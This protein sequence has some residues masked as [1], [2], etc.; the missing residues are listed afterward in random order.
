MLWVAGQPGIDHLRYF[1]MLVEERRD[2][3]GIAAVALHA[4]R[5][6]LDAAQGE[7]RVE[8]A[9]NRADGVLQETELLL[10]RLVPEDGRAANDIRMP[11]EVFR[12]RV[13]HDVEAVLQRLL[14]PRRGEGVVADGN[15]AALA[16]DGGDGLQVDQLEQRIGRGLD[17]DHFRIRLDGLLKR[18]HLGKVRE[19]RADIG[20]ALAHL[21]ED[22]IAAAVEVVHGDDVRARVEEL[23]H[24]A[25]RRH[26]GGEG[27]A[28]FA[29]F[30]LRD[31][32]LE[33]IARGIA[34]ARVVEALVLAR[35]RLR[36]GGGGVDRRHHR[37]GLRIR[38]LP[39]VD[40]LGFKFHLSVLRRSQ[41]SRSM[42]VMRPRNSPLSTTMATRPRSKMPFS[43]S[44][45]ASGATVTRWLSIA[46]VTG[47]L[48][49]PGFSYTSSRMSS[50]STMPTILP[51]LSTGSCETS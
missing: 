29:A 46:S 16:R 47:S 36:V 20:R 13:H 49:C 21:L 3:H 45:L 37:A 30:Q 35:A 31:A 38:P 33:R 51:S 22:E 24:G 25:D 7:E 44:M 15:D 40:D 10:E 19:C 42:R 43:S 34:R 4:H 2:V 12:R 32:G 18:P 41:F 14:D 5:Q 39:G 8:G 26:A 6:R 50:S 17:P 11:V 1:R 9:G 27:E 23:Q 28:G 48:K